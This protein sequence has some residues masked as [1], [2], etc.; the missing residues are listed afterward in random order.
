MFSA[1]GLL[2]S[3]WMGFPLCSPAYGTE[4]QKEDAE[5]APSC[6]A[7]RWGSLDLNLALLTLKLTFF[8]ILF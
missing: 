8:K 6:R 2:V 5:V 4:A 1:V 7:S 3:L